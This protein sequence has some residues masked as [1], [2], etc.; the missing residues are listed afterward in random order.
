YSIVYN[1]MYM[2]PELIL[3]ALA[4]LLLGKVPQIVRKMDV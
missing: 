4:A 1:G 3:T 2:V